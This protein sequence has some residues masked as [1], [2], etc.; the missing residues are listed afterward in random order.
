MLS[1]RFVQ[2]DSVADL[3]P[4]LVSTEPVDG[5]SL[6][7]VLIRLGREDASGVVAVERDDGLVATLAVAGGVLQRLAAEGGDDDA[8]LYERLRVEPGVDATR[9]EAVRERAR[10]D[11]KPLSVS[12]FRAGLATV[13]DIARLLRLGRVDLLKR[14]LAPGRGQIT[15]TPRDDIPKDPIAIPLAPVM[16]AHYRERLEAATLSD[17][18]ARLGNLVFRFPLATFETAM[19]AKGAEG[20]LVEQYCTG[21]LN[22]RTV[23]DK[24]LLGPT[25]GARLLLLLFAFELLDARIEPLRITQNLDVKE[26]VDAR[27]SAVDTN[28]HFEVLDVHWSAHPAEIE[29][30]YHDEVQRF[31]GYLKREGLSDQVATGVRRVRAALDQAWSVLGDPRRRRDFRARNYTHQQ[32]A[33]AAS[34]LH[35]QAELAVFRRD[36]RTA[37]CQLEAAIDLSDDTSYVEALASLRERIHGEKVEAEVKR[38]QK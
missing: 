35:Q 14:C 4:A 38:Q 12:V 10:A 13:Q 22:A 29:A 2:R 1:L 18:E 17:L 36:E 26:A 21:N 33:F 3:S 5:A 11:G 25:R 37:R 15:F 34:F 9:L 32:I 6:G 27:I 20:D 16:F 24:G 8:L 30:K 19:F 31:D 23:I 7:H 28:S